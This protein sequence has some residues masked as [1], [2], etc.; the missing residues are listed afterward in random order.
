M[1]NY[2]CERCKKIFIKKDS[3]IKHTMYKKNP[4]KSISFDSPKNHQISPKN[5]QKPP[6]F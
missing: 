6:K 1:V 2:T 4:C 3:F 5:P